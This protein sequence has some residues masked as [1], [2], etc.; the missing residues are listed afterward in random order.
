VAF[1]LEKARFDR[2]IAAYLKEAREQYDLL[3]GQL[4]LE[5]TA[6]GVVEQIDQL[7]QLNQRTAYYNIVSPLLMQVYH[8][9]AKRSLERKGVDYTRIN[10][11]EGWEDRAEYNPVPHLRR[12]GAMY[13]ELNPIERR[14]L[15][16]G[17]ELSSISLDLFN[18]HFWAFLNQFG[19]LSDSGNDF[20]VPPWEETP[21]VVLGMIAEF[22]DDPNSE[23]S[24]HRVSSDLELLPKGAFVERAVQA[25]RHREQI[26][27]LFTLGVNLFRRAYRLIGE[28]LQEWGWLD[29]VDDVF[30][31]E[32]KELASAIR[33]HNPES[34]FVELV[35]ER[36]QE[37]AQFEQM[38]PP[39]IIYGEQPPPIMEDVRSTWRG[40]PAS[41]GVYRG[42]VCVVKGTSEFSKVVD[43]CVLVIPYSDVSWTPLFARAGAVVAEAGG[44]LSHSSIVAREYGIPAIVS[45]PHATK[46]EDGTMATVDGYTGS[47]ILH[48]TAVGEGKSV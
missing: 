17:R 27:F 29:E 2:E 32:H 47:I 37:Y 43:G 30:Y 6:A 45:V 7:F 42:E 10:W 11:L 1:V 12:L 26:S 41:R 15:A 21:E 38:T 25:S 14:A 28:F 46:L 40:I 39:P 36:K 48:E 19:H 4:I 24:N 22:A 18:R 3:E 16:S 35:R 23:R 9:L 13:R 33:Q 34:S 44:M 8:Q 31:L 5:S 20:A